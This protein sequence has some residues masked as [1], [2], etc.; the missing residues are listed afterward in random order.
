MRIQN[1]V[2]QMDS[3]G[4]A[5]LDCDELQAALRKLGLDESMEQC[6][7]LVDMVDKG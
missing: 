6:K 7:E 4:D 5:E 1:F 3:S 2:A